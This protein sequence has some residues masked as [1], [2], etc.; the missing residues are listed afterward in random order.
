MYSVEHPLSQLNTLE[1]LLTL[2]YF[3]FISCLGLFSMHPGGINQTINLFEQSGC[4]EKEKILEIGCGNGLTTQ[5]LLESNFDV[6]IVE[7]CQY[8]LQTTLNLS[9]KDCKKTPPFYFTNAENL[10]GVPKK[11]FD[12]VLM[13]AVFGFI[14]NKPAAIKQIQSVLNYKEPYYVLMIFIIM[15][16]HLRKY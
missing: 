14:E 3:D 9:L 13:E 6:H 15:K 1:D 2:P 12:K 11:Y 16:S 5:L 7:P 10:D 4:A 8:L